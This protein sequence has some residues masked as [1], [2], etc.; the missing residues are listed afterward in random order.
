M[1]LLQRCSATA[2]LLSAAACAPPGGATEADRQ[3][4]LDLHAFVIEAHVEGDVD[5][6]L[7]VE[8]DDYVSVNRGEIT[9]PTKDDRRSWREPYLASTSFTR[10]ED[11]V[12]PIVKL[13]AD[14]TLGWVIVEVAVEGVRHAPDGTT[15]PVA[16]EAA[17]IELYEK[18][19]GVWT[20]TGNVS[21]MKPAAG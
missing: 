10:Y 11:L 7:A 14:G 20:M 18:R 21:N 16:F 8:S 9:Y 13:S 17:W 3:A 19:G 15:T 12:E 5:G 2:L 4:L 1:M 6:W